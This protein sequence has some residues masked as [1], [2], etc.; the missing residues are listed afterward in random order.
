MVIKELGKIICKD[1]Y[2]RPFEGY[3]F[4]IE[5][6]DHQYILDAHEYETCGAEAWKPELERWRK[7]VEE[8]VGHE[9]IELS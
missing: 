6:T 2:E 3:V 4:E 5:G 9:R 8:L 1:A 7:E